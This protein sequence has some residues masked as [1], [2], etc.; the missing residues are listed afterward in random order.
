MGQQDKMNTRQFTRRNFIKTTALALPLVAA[1]CGSLTKQNAPAGDF[2]TIRNRRLERRGQPYCFIGANFHLAAMLGNPD[3]PG[4]RARLV[5]ELDQLQA[6]GVTNLR[7]LAGS[8]DPLA[9]N[10]G[11]GFTGQPGQWNETFLRGLDFVLVEMAKRNMTGVFYLTNYWEWSGGMAVYVHWATGEPIPDP[12]SSGAG[13]P[14]AAHMTYAA[15][16]YGLPHAQ[17]LFRS[18]VARVLHRR[19]TINGRRYDEDP[20]IMAWQLSN[21]PRPGTDVPA[22]DA[23]LP[24]FYTWMDE[25]ARFIKERAP[26]QLV[27][28]GNEGTMGCLGK[29]DAYLKAHQS[30]AVDYVT[31]HVWVRNWG[32]L[33]EPHLGPQYEEAVALAVQHIEQHMA[34]ADQLGKPLVMEEFGIDRD[35]GRTDPGGRTTMRD[36]Y[37]AK[38]FKRVLTSCQAG[39]A[40]Q[41]TNFW[42]WSGEASAPA[43]ARPGQTDTTE[44]R[45]YVDVNGV[46]ATD[47]TTLAIIRA[48]NQQLANLAG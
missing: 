26:R 12:K 3:L 44:S 31:L 18:H 30:P 48:H 29:T 42:M 9:Q 1:G 13:N 34:L 5:R 36:D 21:E 4:G 22:T 37:Y 23:N 10:G 7:V 45:A 43:H 17:E 46:L 15:R 19:N 32:W 20:T 47:R 38:I 35:D 39:G 16:F 27:S 2:V 24:A 33:K 6:I 11:P 14:G 40:L 8:E 41:A 28:T 25:T